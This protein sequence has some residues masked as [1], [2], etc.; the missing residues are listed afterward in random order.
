[1]HNVNRMLEREEEQRKLKQDIIELNTKLTSTSSRGVS[2]RIKKIEEQ[3]KYSIAQSNMLRGI[4]A[5]Q[6][7]TGMW[8]EPTPA[9]IRKSNEAQDLNSKLCTL[10]NKPLPKRSLN[11]INVKSVMNGVV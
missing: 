10:M 9:Y 6:I 5:R 4:V 3:M 8:H 1:M 11:V 7:T 2:D